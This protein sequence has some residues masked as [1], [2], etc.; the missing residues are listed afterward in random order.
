MSSQNA[1]NAVKFNT[2]KFSPVK[3]PTMAFDNAARIAAIQPVTLPVTYTVDWAL[4]LTRKLDAASQIGDPTA[5]SAVLPVEVLSE[6]WQAATRILA[7][8]PTLLE[9]SKQTH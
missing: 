1:S 3:R 4:S 5:L 6:L 8:E 2:V 7:T 9:V